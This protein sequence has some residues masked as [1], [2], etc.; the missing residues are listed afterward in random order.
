MPLLPAPPLVLPPTPAPA[1]RAGH[2]LRASAAALLLGTLGLTGLSLPALAQDA[3]APAAAAP[4]A[5]APVR[6][7]MD[8]VLFYQLL[9]SELEL[10]DGNAPLAYQVMMEAARRSRD[11]AL[12]RRAVDIALG[13]RAG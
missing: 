10:R 12:F 4:A 2:R 5:P 1:S 9:V 8:G 11:E 13:A 6:S 7:A 3:A